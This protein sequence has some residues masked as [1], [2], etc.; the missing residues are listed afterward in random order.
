M[1]FVTM[2]IVNNPDKL[3][4]K[5]GDAW[6]AWAQEV[7]TCYIHSWTF[8]NKQEYFSSVTKETCSSSLSISIQ[9]VHTQTEMQ[10]GSFGDSLKML[11]DP[12]KFWTGT[13]LSFLWGCSAADGQMVTSL[14]PVPTV[15][16]QD[17]FSQWRPAVQTGSESVC[18]SV[19]LFIFVSVYTHACT[20][21]Y[22]HICVFS[23][24]F[25]VS[26]VIY[27]PALLPPLSLMP[28]TGLEEHS[29]RK[30]LPLVPLS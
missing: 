25:H 15:I 17:S 24:L 26:L 3:L 22:L 14:P 27:H 20:C 18:L 19:S 28:V 4:N 11:G 21:A 9:G 12:G 1:C 8:N 16:W 29:W 7:S 30:I 2:P 6:L 13:L 23:I 5:Q 10:H